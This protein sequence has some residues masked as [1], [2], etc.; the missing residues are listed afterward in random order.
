MIFAVFHLFWFEQ[1]FTPTFIIGG[2]SSRTAVATKTFGV[3]HIEIDLRM[4]LVFDIWFC[5]CIIIQMASQTTSAAGF[6]INGSVMLFLVTQMTS[7]AF[8]FEVY[9]GSSLP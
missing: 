7:S 3:V 1:S 6:F 4:N 9:I 8:V 2:Y 5:A